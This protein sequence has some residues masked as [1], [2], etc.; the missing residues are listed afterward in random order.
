MSDCFQSQLY[1]KLCP[2]AQ[3]YMLYGLDAEIEA[4]KF[5]LDDK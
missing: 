5:G 4:E 1:A 3:K 2:L